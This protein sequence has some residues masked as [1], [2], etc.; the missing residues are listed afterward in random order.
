MEDRVKKQIYLKENILN[1]GYDPN[2]FGAYMISLKENG[3][4]IN[5]WTFE[6]LESIVHSFTK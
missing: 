5:N 3:N 4:D 2:E 1:K 6:E